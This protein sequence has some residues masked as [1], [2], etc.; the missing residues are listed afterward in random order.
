M[1]RSID[2]LSDENERPS[3]PKRAKCTNQ[4]DAHASSDDR[5]D[6]LPSAAAPE[7]DPTDKAEVD[8]SSRAAYRD[9]P[10]V[11]GDNT[12]IR[13][14]RILPEKT[15]R[16][17][18]C[19]LI[20]VPV[21]GQVTYTALS[22][23]WGEVRYPRSIRLNDRPVAV[24]ENLWQFLNQMHQEC[25]TGYFWIDALC[26]NQFDIQE[27]NHQVKMMGE[28][29]STAEQVVVWLGPEP[30]LPRHE[31]LL[32]IIWV[33][34]C[35]PC[36][37]YNRYKKLRYCMQR[38]SANS[39]WRRTWTVQEV[40]LAQCIE[41]RSGTDT[42]D[43]NILH[44]LY[45]SSESGSN[46]PSEAGQSKKDLDAEWNP[47]AASYIRLRNTRRSRLDPAR[48]TDQ[49][50]RMS[51][52]GSEKLPEEVI[53]PSL[54]HLV[55]QFA[56]T[57]CGD[58]RD[59]VYALLSL[60]DPEELERGPL[61]PD[62]SKPKHELLLDLTRRSFDYWSL[63]DQSFIARPEAACHFMD[64]VSD[65]A[66]LLRL[67]NPDAAQRWAMRVVTD[68]PLS[69]AIKAR[70]SMPCFDHR[71]SHLG[72]DSL[73]AIGTSGEVLRNREPMQPHLA[74]EVWRILEW[75]Q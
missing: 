65:W 9:V 8:L 35:M 22:Y 16:H 70:A 52:T 43:Q 2:C 46:L 1:K 14:L 59:H 30:D 20:V 72:R 26:I 38:L 5:S 64:E 75:C 15:R 41:I 68:G 63:I 29:Y 67:K 47:T 56:E 17:I 19:E 39:Y 23:V 40:V 7:S 21:R 6:P 36:S 58:P 55:T 32:N 27:R 51:I 33:V 48:A 13:V 37:T 73:P 34:V 10:L 25:R 44:Q 74:S 49:A 62:Y 24:R 31:R 45:A 18:T 69:P 11:H 50:A 57:E 4:A 42:L 60:V 53:T 66:T 3:K 12:N 61:S 54:R 71:L 28:I